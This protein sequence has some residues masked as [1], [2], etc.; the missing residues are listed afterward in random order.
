MKSNKEFLTYFD[1]ITETRNTGAASLLGEVF[2][3]FL[4]S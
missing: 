1:E 2:D 4:H 3:P